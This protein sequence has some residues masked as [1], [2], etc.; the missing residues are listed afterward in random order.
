MRQVIR[1]GYLLT[2]RG[3]GKEAKELYLNCATDKPVKI[4][5]EVLSYD[6]PTF[7]SPWL[8]GA[9]GSGVVTLTGPISGSKTVLDFNRISRQESSE[10][11]K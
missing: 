7:D 4:G 8:K 2:Y 9:F 1:S 11:E 6:C 10:K 5:G 3:C